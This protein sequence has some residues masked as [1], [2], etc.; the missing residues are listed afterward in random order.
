MINNDATLFVGDK[1]VL[2]SKT[3]QLNEYTKDPVKIDK[4][5]HDIRVVLNN[6]SNLN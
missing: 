6:A 3:Y 4:G 1:K 2:A 5:N